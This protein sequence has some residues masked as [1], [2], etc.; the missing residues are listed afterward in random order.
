MSPEV[1]K[2]LTFRMRFLNSLSGTSLSK[3]RN[4]TSLGASFL[5]RCMRPYS[6]SMPF[7]LPDRFAS[8]AAILARMALRTSTLRFFRFRSEGVGFKL[9]GA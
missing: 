5:L 3:L 7:A 2:I 9:V 4:A 8:L 6:A 1:S